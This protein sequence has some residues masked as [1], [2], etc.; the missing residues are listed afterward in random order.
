M[1]W[2]D[3]GL[4]QIAKVSIQAKQI[5]LFS[6]LDTIF[7]SQY[8]IYFLLI[9]LEHHGSLPVK[10]QEDKINKCDSQTHRKSDID[11]TSLSKQVITAFI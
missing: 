11:R 5:C 6:K 1:L 4:Q 8:S 7:Q 9:S 2:V 3:N 10:M